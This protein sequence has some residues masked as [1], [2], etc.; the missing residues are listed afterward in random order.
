MIRYATEKFDFADKGVLWEKFMCLVKGIQ[1]FVKRFKDSH[2]YY[3]VGD[4]YGEGETVECIK[5]DYEE[6]FWEMSYR[7]VGEC[8]LQKIKL[9]IFVRYATI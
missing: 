9:T 4:Y 6:L 5:D 2:Y 8:F 3:T 7:K 1:D